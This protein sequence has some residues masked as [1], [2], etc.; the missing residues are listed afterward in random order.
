METV[1]FFLTVFCGVFGAYVILH[2][3]YERFT[4]L[5]KRG[6]TKNARNNGRTAHNKRNGGRNNL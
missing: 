3:L 2:I 6:R 1:F 5:I 4:E